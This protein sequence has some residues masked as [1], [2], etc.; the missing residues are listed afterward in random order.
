[1]NTRRP[2]AGG[3]RGSPP[4]YRDTVTADEGVTSFEGCEFMPWSAAT[5]VIP[6]AAMDAI[7]KTPAHGS[8]SALFETSCEV[9]GLDSSDVPDS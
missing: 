8:T 3:L 4:F 9:G 2:L 7:K 5:A 6:N 1:M